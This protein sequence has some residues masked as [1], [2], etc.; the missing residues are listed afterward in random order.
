MSHVF[1]R[2]VAKHWPAG[3]VP[4]YAVA[5]YVFTGA[6][7]VDFGDFHPAETVVLFGADAV[8]ASGGD[9][10]PIGVV[11]AD[12]ADSGPVPAELVAS[13]TNVNG[14]PFVSPSTT[15][16]VA[17]GFGEHFADPGDA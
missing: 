4:A 12:G 8:T 3:V 2:A 1:C 13:T 9:G 14:L 10:G 15:H 16:E 5:V 11:G 6:P 17:T 7:P